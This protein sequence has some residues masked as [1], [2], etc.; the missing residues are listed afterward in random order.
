MIIAANNN[1]DNTSYEENQTLPTCVQVDVCVC[2]GLG[3]YFNPKNV[4]TK[5]L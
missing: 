5:C 3:L 4:K 1:F 2:V